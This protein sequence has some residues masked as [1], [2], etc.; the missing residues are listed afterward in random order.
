M[1]KLLREHNIYE[2]WNEDVAESVLFSNSFGKKPNQQDLIDICVRE[3]WGFKEINALKGYIKKYIHVFKEKI[4]TNSEW[5]E[6]NPLPKNPKGK[7]RVKC[8]YCGGCGWKSDDSYSTFAC[9]WCDKGW[10]EV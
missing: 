10:V 6:P 9:P 4:Y 8:G 7:K 3:E 2:V 5:I 1:I